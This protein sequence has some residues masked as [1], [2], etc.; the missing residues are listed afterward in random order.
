MAG[1]GPPGP[2]RGSAKGWGLRL[3]LLGVLLGLP[4]RGRAG[5]AGPPPQ[6]E[7]VTPHWLLGGRVRRAVSLEEQ[8]PAPARAEVAVTA[9]GKELVL[10][11]ERNQ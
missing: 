1:P 7:R 4:P 11:L 5:P 3:A 6:G 10:V 8:V 2:R 9:E